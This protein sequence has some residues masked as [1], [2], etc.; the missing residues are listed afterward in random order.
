MT[1]SFLKTLF[2]LHVLQF[3]NGFLLVFWSV[4]GL[5]V[6]SPP[7]YD[8]ISL[9]L[10]SCNERETKFWMKITGEQSTLATV[11]SMNS[12]EVNA[13]SSHSSQQF[14]SPLFVSRSSRQCAMTSF[15]VRNCLENV[16]NITQLFTIIQDDN[17]N[18]D[19]HCTVKQLS[20]QFLVLKIATLMQPSTFPI[21]GF[22]GELHGS[23]NVNPLKSFNN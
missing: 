16:A 14:C 13:G 15:F 22:D 1:P 20:S 18:H 17:T 10:K 11:L 9:P 12:C 23:R 5:D 8:L 19:R 21:R 3:G 2:P 6:T 4:G 7:K